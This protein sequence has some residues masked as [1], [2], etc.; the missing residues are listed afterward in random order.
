MDTAGQD[1]AQPVQA[2]FGALLRAYRLAAG[3]TQEELAERA[4]M[5][6]KGLGALENG[7]RQAPT[8]TPWRCWPAP[9]ASRRAMPRAGGRA[10]ALAQPAM[11]PGGGSAGAA[12][13]SRWQAL[14]GFLLVARVNPDAGG[15]SPV[16]PVLLK[17]FA[18]ISQLRDDSCRPLSHALLRQTQ[19][20]RR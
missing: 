4:G 5:S 9:W 14:D 11:A 1:A 6:A 15:C 20:S 13:G 7:R 18:T 2:T 8:G 17:G 12:G 16:R 3:L 19:L 10:A